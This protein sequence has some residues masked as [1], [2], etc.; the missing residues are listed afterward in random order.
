MGLRINSLCVYVRSS[1][2]FV[3]IFLFQN[4]TVRE[5]LRGV[6]RLTFEHSKNLAVFVGIYKAVLAVLRQTQELRE[7]PAKAIVGKP[8]AHWHAAVAGGVGGYLVWGKYSSVNYQIVMYLLSRIIISVVK[9]LAA[10]GYK[11]FTDHKFNSVYPALATVVW[12][13]VM[14]LYENERSTLHPSL[15]KSMDF[16]YDESCKW[17][18]GVADFLPSAATTAVGL[19]T[20]LKI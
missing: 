1:I 13:S 2:A 11:P 19:L 17:T 4:G 8:A 15:S 5:K 3:M 6:V 12:A 7:G 14:W 10:R 16:L 20:W 18:N 9:V